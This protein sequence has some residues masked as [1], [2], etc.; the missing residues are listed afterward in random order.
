MPTAFHGAGRPGDP[1]VKLGHEIRF[2]G[3]AESWSYLRNV[4]GDA[5]CMVRKEA[6]D[7]ANLGE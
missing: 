3:A 5:A 4:V 7:R 2:I 6:F 1:G